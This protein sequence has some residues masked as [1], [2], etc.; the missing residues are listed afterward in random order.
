MRV[1]QRFT[2]DG[3]DFI[4]FQI[5][6]EDDPPKPDPPCQMQPGNYRV[7][8]GELYRVVRGLPPEWEGDSK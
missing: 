1:E 8:D 5:Y 4:Y 6:G 7:I 2:I 3:Q